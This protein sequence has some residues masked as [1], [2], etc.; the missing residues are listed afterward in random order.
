[1][2]GREFEIIIF[3]A[4]G[5]TGRL[6][7]QY[8][9]K[10][11]PDAR[12]AMAG[13]SAQKLAD[14][15]DIIG[16][17]KDT[18]LIVADSGEPHS[19]DAMAARADAVIT[20]VGPYQLYGEA[21]LAACVA[22]GTDYVDLCGEPAWMHD[23]IEKYDAAAKASGA[24]IVLSCGFD[25][26]PFDL[27]VFA[28]QQAAIAKSGAPITRVKGRVRKMAGTLSGGT[29]ASFAESMKR[30]SREPEVIAWLQDPFSLCPDFTG[31]K[32][33]NDSKPVYD[34]DLKSWAAPFMMAAINTKN[35]HRSNAL[36][37]HQY[38]ADFA[39]D[40]MVMTGDGE[41][42]E[43]IA[44]GMAKQNPFA[45]PLKPGEGP[46]LEER[47]AGF[48]DLMFT[49]VTK[50]GERMSAIVTGDKD[51]GYG[52]TSKMISEAA[53]CL[54]R[55]V[56]KSQTGGGVYTAAP[57]MGAALIARLTTHAGLTFDIT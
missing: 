55:D 26:I 40:E 24:R 3:G 35:I 47:E 16:A 9:A 41:Q 48:Y 36:L 17:P 57:A 12:W 27:G 37:G 29:A 38:G 42:G 14:V 49:G 46:S 28:V 30:A 18:P 39:Y 5:F 10:S 20:T 43:A 53:L 44:N 31:P 32:Q 34:E 50:D 6:V 13:R 15:R 2:S 33:P 52:S 25:S 51:P 19:L 21:L 54:T 11:Y 45:K 22:G 8:L 7:A 4:T 23:I 56:S 1:M